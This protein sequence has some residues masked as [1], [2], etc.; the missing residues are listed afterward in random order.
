MP[1][2]AAP[3]TGPR[4][5]GLGV[6]DQGRGGRGRL[7]LVLVLALV[8]AGVIVVLGVLGRL[9]SASATRAWTKAQE[10]PTVR[11]ITPASE[12]G[13]Q[14][15][16]LPGTLQAYYNAQI[17]ARVPGYVH[18]WYQDIGAKVRK[19]Q[20]LA[21]IDTPELDQQL[22]QAKAD[23]A[24]AEANKELSE[25]T[26]RRWTALLAQ[27]AV[28]K[29]ESDEKSGDFKVKTALVNAAKA[30]VQRLEALKA[31]ARIQAPF[32]GYVT[33]RKTDIGA[34][35]NAGAGGTSTSELFDVGEVD[36]LRLYVDVPQSDIARIKP[37]DTATLTVPEHP[38]KS[39]KGKLVSTSNAVSDGSG[40]LLAELLVA[41]PDDA[42]KAG[43]YATVTFD[44]PPQ[45]ADASG[46]LR[47][48]S[49]A[50]L[51]LSQG[52]EAAVVGPDDRVTLK[53]VAV[54]R[55]L[56]S[57]IEVSSGLSPTDRLIDNPPDSITS[58][59]LVRVAP[60]DGPAAPGPGG[61]HG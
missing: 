42:L 16:V 11:V 23:L 30:N 12:T 55:D 2:D 59:E 29:Q 50:L 60:N 34:L 28:S 21:T 7:K 9:N 37:G 36:K 48:P 45:G 38:G 32:D 52:L 3:P 43:D 15:L 1:I 6:A 5:P 24:S 61:G 58:G 35:V 17:Y 57:T 41:N 4:R 26:A 39:F 22:I 44:L 14:S 53:R 40:T 54:G 51:F 19:G 25:V 56:G 20:V 33:A 8:L 49:S 27:D 13:A 46:Y 18:A 31:F 10:V 47:V